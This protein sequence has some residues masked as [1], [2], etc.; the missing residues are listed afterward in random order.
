MVLARARSLLCEK[1]KNIYL[2]GTALNTLNPEKLSA[3]YLECV[4]A[5][6]LI[7][8]LQSAVHEKV[9]PMLT[10]VILRINT[11]LEQLC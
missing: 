4:L 10:A 1:K 7:A 11:L 6:W 3:C 2:Y 9:Y 8:V 5:L